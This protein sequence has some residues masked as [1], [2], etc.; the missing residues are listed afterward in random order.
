ME[1]PRPKVK[2]HMIWSIITTLCCCLPLGIGA[3]IC[4]RRVDKANLEGDVTWAEEASRKAK[5]LNITGLV[6]GILLMAIFVILKLMLV[7]D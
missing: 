2:S 4:S 7:K 6:C 3:I 5:I 1:A